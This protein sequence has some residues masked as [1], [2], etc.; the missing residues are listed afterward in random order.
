[1][2]VRNPA[3]DTVRSLYMV[4]DI[5]KA[6]VQHND[7]AR[8]RLMTAGTKVF[9]KQEGTEARRTGNETHYRVLAEGLPV[10]LPFVGPRAV[11]VADFA[12][13]KG[14]MEAYYPLTT[15]FAEPFRSTIEAKGACVYSRIG[16]AGCASPGPRGVAN[17]SPLRPP[18]PENGSYVVR[19]QPGRLENGAT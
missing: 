18:T 11:I 3:G 19:F 8:I 2:L 5:V 4:N 16:V 15:G 13:L 1:M 14:M 12:A 17:Y 9:G 10:V 7:F 6:I